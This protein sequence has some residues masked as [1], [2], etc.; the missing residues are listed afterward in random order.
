MADHVP[1]LV[2]LQASV[3]P[4]EESEF[5]VLVDNMFVKY[6]TIDAGLYDCDDMCFGPSLISLLPPLPPGDWNQGYVSRNPETGE[7]HFSAVS[8]TQLPGI[9]TTWHPTRVD[10]LELREERKIRSNVY[11]VTCPCFNSTVI[12][13]FARFEWEVPQ[14]E[15]E[16]TAYEWIEGQQIGP[17][18]L[19]HL[20]EDGRIIGFLMARIADC[21]HATPEDF[22][23]CHS[24][25]SKLH[26]LGIK[27]GDINKHNFLINDGKA[28]LIDFDRA[29]RAASHDELESELRELED[30]LGDTS[31]R[32]GRAVESRLG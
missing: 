18:F 20:T 32:G 11:E 23:L 25:L 13:K 12:A 28:T 29:S 9:T 8:N 27:H 30:Q 22:P 16:T 1:K 6:I 7:P 19:G 5:R 24:A 3:D 14:L 26:E 15:A 10:H 21:R 4:D 17:A 2:V 31:G